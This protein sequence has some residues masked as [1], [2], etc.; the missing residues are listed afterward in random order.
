MTWIKNLPKGLVAVVVVLLLAA[1]FLVLRGGGDQ[2]TVVA[3]FSRAVSLF[4]GSEVR[5]L[6][7]HVGEVLSVVPEGNTVRVEMTYDTDFPV[8]EGAKAVIITPTLTADRFVQ[9]TPAYDGEGPVLKDGDEIEVQD[10][11]VPVELDRIYRSLSDLTE[12][13]GPNGVNKNGTLNNVLKAGSKFLEGQGRKANTTIINLSRALKTF[14]DGSSDLFGAVAAL[15]E[16]AGALAADDDAVAAFMQ[17]LGDVSQQLAGEKDELYG[18]LKNLADVLGKVEGFV[19]GNRGLLTSSVK[20]LGRILGTIAAEKTALESVLEI[21]PTAMGNLV[22]AWDPVTSTIGSRI[23]LANNFLTLDDLVCQVM[24]S[25]QLPVA[26]QAC[27]LLKSLLGPALRPARAG[28]A[29][30]GRTGAAVEEQRQLGSGTS[31]SDLG[32]LL[33]GGS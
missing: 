6:G 15:N 14:G 20:D 4:P 12:A 27:T 10:T 21:G 28:D 25:A 9:L 26:G 33:G 13:L 24:V 32:Q 8:P 22:N 5:I 7:V 2:R 18:A 16:F 11:G 17:D 31:A 30:V 29:T 19:K 23:G 3:H 1:G